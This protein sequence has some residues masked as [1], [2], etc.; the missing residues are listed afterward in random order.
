MWFLRRWGVVRLKAFPRASPC[1]SQP[2]LC[3]CAAYIGVHL[4][5]ESV[6]SCVVSKQLKWKIV[7]RLQWNCIAARAEKAQMATQTWQNSTIYRVSKSQGPD[8]YQTSFP[9]FNVGSLNPT[10]KHFRTSLYSFSCR[11]RCLWLSGLGRRFLLLLLPHLT[12]VPSRLQVWLRVAPSNARM[13]AAEF[14]RTKMQLGF[15]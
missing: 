8:Q 6:L 4:W 1:I 12:E 11:W 15:S 2:S 10:W 13:S 7:Q 5:Q 14:A 9:D 3:L